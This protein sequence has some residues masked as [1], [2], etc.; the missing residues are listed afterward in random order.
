[1]YTGKRSAQS[2]YIA[3]RAQSMHSL[4]RGEMLQMYYKDRN[5]VHVPYQERDMRYDA[6]TRGYLRK[7]G[8]GLGA[9]RGTLRREP[10]GAGKR[11]RGGAGIGGPKKGRK[12]EAA[13]PREQSRT[14]SPTQA[15]KR[16][17]ESPAR[18]EKRAW[19]RE[20]P[21]TVT[22]APRPAPDISKKMRPKNWGKEG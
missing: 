5:G 12:Q 8:G 3:E 19:Q 1:M 20:C 17:R 11:G 7:E 10:V 13:T 6:G 15:R 22:Q 18:A 14:E 9:Q 21:V 2:P 16:G 4:T